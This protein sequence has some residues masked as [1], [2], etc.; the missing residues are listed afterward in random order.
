MLHHHSSDK[1]S[2]VVPIDIDED[3]AL[4]LHLGLM[5]VSHS[6]LL[7]GV[8]ARG[9]TGHAIIAR[10]QHFTTIIIAAGRSQNDCNLRIRTQ[11]TSAAWQ[12]QAAA[13]VTALSCR[14][15]AWIHTSGHTP[16]DTPTSKRI[17][18]KR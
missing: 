9:W 11:G 8:I 1:N 15:F 6:L 5:M 12:E 14:Q 18:T 4:V 2:A 13:A 7:P 3:D 17:R 10:M 16:A